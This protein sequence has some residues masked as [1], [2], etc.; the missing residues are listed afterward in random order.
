MGGSS[1]AADAYIVNTLSLQ[2][3]DC[4]F[5]IITLHCEEVGIFSSVL[6]FI[7]RTLAHTGKKKAL[8][9]YLYIGFKAIQS[10]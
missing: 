3:C 6:Y 9:E 1:V 8:F 2:L 7:A 5:C 4:R 10:I